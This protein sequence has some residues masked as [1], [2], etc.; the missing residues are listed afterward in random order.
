MN[1]K[2]KKEEGEGEALRRE[3]IKRN[4]LKAGVFLYGF[5]II[6]MKQTAWV[7]FLSRVV[8]GNFLQAVAAATG[9]TTLTVAIG[10]KEGER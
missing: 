10:L 6:I 4:Q 1:K 9:M 7:G 5:E 8:I 3:E 2:K